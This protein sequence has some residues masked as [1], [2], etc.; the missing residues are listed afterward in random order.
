MM[1]VTERL[2]IIKCICES[3]HHVSGMILVK[4]TIVGRTITMFWI[5]VT[6]L[7]IINNIWRELGLEFQTIQQFYF[8]KCR[9]NKAQH[10]T[11]VH[12][13][14]RKRNWVHI[15]SYWVGKIIL[16]VS[17][18]IQ[19]WLT[20]GIHNIQRHGIRERHSIIQRASTCTT[21][22]LSILN[23]IR[24]FCIHTHRQPF[25]CIRLHIQASRITF[26]M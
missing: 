15:T 1:G 16:S 24:E 10:L 14:I 12:V 23:S 21:C 7:V 17:I 5:P 18:S 26:I 20:I 9:T 11:T 8:R 6:M 22:H 25:G 2:R 19:Y 3:I 4:T 13:H